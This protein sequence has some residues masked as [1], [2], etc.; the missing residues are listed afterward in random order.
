MV[1]H[2]ANPTVEPPAS[3]ARPPVAVTPPKN[4]PR[5]QAA[6]LAPSQPPVPSMVGIPRDWAPIVAPR[7]WEWIVIHHSATPVGGAARFGRE[8]QAKGWDELG[9]HFVIGNGS[10][11]ANGLVEVGSRWPKQKQGAHTKTP[12]NNF[13]EKGIG[14]CLVGDFDV[15]RPTEAQLRA[16]A[17]LTAYLMKTYRIPAD[18]IIGHCDAKATHCPGKNLRIAQL[19]SMSIQALAAAGQ[20]P[21]PA[22]L[23]AATPGKELLVDTRR[24]VR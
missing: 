3:P 7:R 14:I 6:P 22:R 12:D 23:A 16:V 13:N 20:T 9:Y 11:T 15:A 18:H 5:Q 8:H 1:E 4:A 19:R 17:K 10:D 2:T 24:A 21:P